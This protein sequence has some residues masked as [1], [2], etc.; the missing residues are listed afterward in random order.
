MQALRTALVAGGRLGDRVGGEVAQYAVG[1]R[2]Q[3]IAAVP[4]EVWVGVGLGLGLVLGWVL[5][6]GVRV[7]VPAVRPLEAS[8]LEEGDPESPHVRRGSVVRGRRLEGRVG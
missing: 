1:E 6:L 8:Q 7:R 3:R 5:E 2:G 4:T